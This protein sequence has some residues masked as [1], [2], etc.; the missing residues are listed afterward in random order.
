MYRPQTLEDAMR[1][2]IRAQQDIMNMESMIFSCFTSTGIEDIPQVADD[3][4]VVI[5]LMQDTTT[6]SHDVLRSELHHQ[7]DP[8]YQ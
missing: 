2:D 3:D 5:E 4:E 1:M 6:R 7:I 8:S